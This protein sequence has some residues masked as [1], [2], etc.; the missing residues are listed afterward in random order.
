MEFVLPTGGQSNTYEELY[1]EYLADRT[2]FFNSEV[3]DDMVE[4]IVMYIIKWNKEDKN[5]P[6]EKRKPIKI[7]MS[8]VGGDTFVAQNVVDVILQSKTPVIGI[9]LSLVASA[10]YHCFL[11]CHERLAF[12]NPVFLQHDG[13]ISISNSANKARQTMDFLESGEARSKNFVLSRTK[14]SEELYDKIFDQEFYMYSDKA[15][16][17]G[18]V[19]KI[20]GEDIDF[21]EVL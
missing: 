15:K 2:L 7:Y 5:L 8:S 16:E 9:G 3:D 14:M 20:I 6:I 4:D 11:A 12:K 13:S 18:V 1:R 17:L 19:D 10:C 21:E